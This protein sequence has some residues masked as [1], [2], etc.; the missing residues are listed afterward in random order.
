MD[1]LSLAKEYGPWLA[2]VVAVLLPA[3]RDVVPSLIK[4]EDRVLEAL[5]NNNTLLAALQ[6]TLEGMNDQLGEQSEAIH[7]LNE[8]VAG[9]YGQV[10][11]QRP[12]RLGGISG[13]VT[14]RPKP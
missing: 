4:R 13:T 7:R 6:R 1:F 8:D 2:L 10:G 3:L 14:Q 5:I 9:L 11:Q 12:S